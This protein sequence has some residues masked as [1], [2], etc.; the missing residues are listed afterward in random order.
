MAHRYLE[1]ARSAERLGSWGLGGGWVGLDSLNWLLL[2]IKGV[3]GGLGGEELAWQAGQNE[4]KALR[5]R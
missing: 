1:N 4:A 3:W 2:L 5:Q